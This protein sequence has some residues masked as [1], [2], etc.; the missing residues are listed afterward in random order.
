MVFKPVESAQARRRAITGTQLVPLV[1]T[2]AQV[3]NGVLVE[4][5]EVDVA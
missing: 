1:R 5:S 2:G 3:E 4:R